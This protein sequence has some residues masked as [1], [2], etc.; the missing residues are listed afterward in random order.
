MI[1]AGR[2]L[3]F[4]WVTN[5]ADRVLLD[6]A[7]HIQRFSKKEAAQQFLSSRGFQLAHEDVTVYDFARIR[8]WCAAPIA[9]TD[10]N[11]LLDTWNMLSDIVASAAHPNNLMALADRQADASYE[12]LF[13]ACNLPSSTPPG[14][15]FIPTWSTQEIESLA[16]LFR[17]AFVHL[18]T[19]IGAD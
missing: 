10:P 17:L 9:P 19:L 5:G 12:K 13:F 14:E 1:D 11:E 18:N 8:A 15:R 4:V 2:D 6:P 3:L 7:G 16:R